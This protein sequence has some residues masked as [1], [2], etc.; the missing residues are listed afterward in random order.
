MN[1]DDWP[2]ARE[3]REPEKS[4]EAGLSATNDLL[5]GVTRAMELRDELLR[6]ANSYSGD[7]TGNTAIMLHQACNCIL[8]ANK[9]IVDN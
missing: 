7:E 2:S 8:N 4:D 9:S 1:Y 6:I 5:V 3:K